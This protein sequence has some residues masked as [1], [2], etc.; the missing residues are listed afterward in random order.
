MS[1]LRGKLLQIIKDCAEYSQPT[2]YR[3]LAAS[4][5]GSLCE[6]LDNATVEEGLFAQVMVLCQDT[7]YEVVLL[8]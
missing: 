8:V 7:E 4:S 3:A 1:T 5:V 2:P 6:L